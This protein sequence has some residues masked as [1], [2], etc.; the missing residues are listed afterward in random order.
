MKDILQGIGIGFLA[1]LAIGAGLFIVD[2]FD[3]STIRRLYFVG[4][5]IVFIFCSC[6]VALVKMV[7]K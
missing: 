2:W 3:E 4:G 6:G 5:L 1:I 7:K